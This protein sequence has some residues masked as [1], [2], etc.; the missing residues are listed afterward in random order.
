MVQGGLEIACEVT[1]IMQATLKN[2][3][4]LDRSKELVNDYYTE[5]TDEKILGSFLT[6]IFHD[7]PVQTQESLPFQRKEKKRLNSEVNVPERCLQRD[8]NPQPLRS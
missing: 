5:P 6:T 1:V 7:S 3:M 4:I 2:H 8:S